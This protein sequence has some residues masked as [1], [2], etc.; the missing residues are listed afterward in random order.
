MK[1]WQVGGG[2]GV[3]TKL[4]PKAKLSSEESSADDKSSLLNLPVFCSEI[5]HGPET[6]VNNAKPSQD[7]PDLPSSEWSAIPG[8]S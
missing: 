3:V 8:H 2:V 1:A 4:S 7:C 5:K 6:Y